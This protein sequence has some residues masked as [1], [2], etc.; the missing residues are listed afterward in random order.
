[1]FK[2]ILKKEK[3]FKLI[4]N[5]LLITFIVF[6]IVGGCGGGDDDDGNGGNQP[7]P[8]PPSATFGSIRGSVSSSTGTPLN[9]VHVRAV[10]TSDPDIQISTFSGIDTNLSLKDGAFDIQNVPPGSYKVLIEQMNSRSGAFDPDRYSDFVIV[11]NLNLVFLGISF[12]DEFYNGNDES[13]GDDP[14]AFV[15]VSVVGGQVASGIDFITND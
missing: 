15:V 9:G 14:N 5:F 8:P 3:T 2:S 11:E 4:L 10:N 13:T 7:P 12:P 1:M 6:G